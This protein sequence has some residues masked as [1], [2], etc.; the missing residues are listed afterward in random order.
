VCLSVYVLVCVCVCACACVTVCLSVCMC[1][2]SA[3]LCMYVC[4]IVCVLVCVCLCACMCVCVLCFSASLLDISTLS[5]TACTALAEIGRRS[6]LPLHSYTDHLTTDQLTT[7]SVV[8]K[9][10]NKVKSTS[11]NAKVSFYLLVACLSTET[12]L[13]I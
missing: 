10:V 13:N 9:L 12:R 2:L 6:G 1:L 11:E 4:L 3:C 8:E 7:A 5:V